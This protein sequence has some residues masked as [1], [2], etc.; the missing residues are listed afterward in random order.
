MKKII[1]SFIMTALLALAIPALSGTAMA[2]TRRYYS[3]RRTT[4]YYTPDRTTD[5]YDSGAPNVYDRHRKAINIGVATGVGAVI[6]A[7]F[8]G[9]K[10]AAIGAAAGVAGGAIITAKQAPRNYYHYRY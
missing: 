10:G 2:Q 5:Y 7:L 3:E 9:K 1:T 4:R 8:G 6:G